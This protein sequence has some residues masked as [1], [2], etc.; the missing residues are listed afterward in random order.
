MTAVAPVGRPQV[1]A[2]SSNPAT[3][4]SVPLVLRAYCCF[5]IGVTLLELCLLFAGDA[6]AAVVPFVGWVYSMPYAFSIFFACFAASS[7]KYGCAIYGVRWFLIFAIAIGLFD[8]LWGFAVED[9]G[10][11]YLRVSPWRPLFTVLLPIVWLLLLRTKIVS[12]YVAVGT[13]PVAQ[14]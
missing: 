7:P 8:F 2:E 11:P 5:A 3:A 12:Q 9:F 4:P 10:N 14:H 6:A 13:P 1:M